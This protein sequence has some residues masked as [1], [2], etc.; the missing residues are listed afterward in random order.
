MVSLL[1]HIEHTLRQQ[2]IAERFRTS[3]VGAMNIR[4]IAMKGKLVYSLTDMENILRAYTEFRSFV[5]C[6]V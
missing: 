1:L 4:I 3:F 6:A 2:T 5:Q